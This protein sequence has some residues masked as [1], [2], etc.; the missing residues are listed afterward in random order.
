LYKALK[1]IGVSGMQARAAQKR[2]KQKAQKMGWAVASKAK[3]MK[4]ASK[5]K[6]FV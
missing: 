6:I 2:A 1:Q 3:V 5:K 4:T